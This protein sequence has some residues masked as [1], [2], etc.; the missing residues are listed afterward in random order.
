[1]KTLYRSDKLHVY[2]DDS[3]VCSPYLTIETGKRDCT[4][5]GISFSFAEL[6][7]EMN[8]AEHYNYEHTGTDST[9]TD[10]VMRN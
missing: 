9:R 10:C 7:R 3:D 1:M 4:G 5:T 8:E 6:R 2:I